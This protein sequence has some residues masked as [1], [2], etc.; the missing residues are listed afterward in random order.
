MA[1]ET[2]AAAVIAEIKRMANA[3]FQTPEIQY[4]LATELTPERARVWVAHQAYFVRNRRDCW[5][6]ASSLAPLDVKR[7]IWKHEEDELVHDPR[8]GT[9]HFE[10]IAEQA[11]MFGVSREELAGVTLH[12]FVGAALDAWVL[13]G[14]GPWLEAFTAV[15]TMEVVNNNAVIAG[16]GFSSRMREKLVGEL[17]YEPSRLRDQNVH[18]AADQEHTLI[19]DE[20]L[21]E[22]VPDEAAAQA[23]L[24]AAARS[25]DINR[26]YRGGIAFAMRQ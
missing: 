24:R 22:H 5:A 12:P 9:D 15:A 20:V 21:S 17:G 18:V 7:R 6:L 26:A 23:A 16:G 2:R 4:F 3:H 8:A 10:L 1:V 13:L 25:L 14:R 11:A 19:L